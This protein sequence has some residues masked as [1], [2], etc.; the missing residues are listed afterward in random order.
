MLQYMLDCCLS[1][2]LTHSRQTVHCRV[3]VVTNF[4]SLT[5]LALLQSQTQETKACEVELGDMEGSVML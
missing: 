5:V 1:T 3:H 2:R 4:A